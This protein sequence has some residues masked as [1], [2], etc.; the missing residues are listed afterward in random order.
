MYIEVDNDNYLKRSQPTEGEKS[1]ANL[2]NLAS[3]VGGFHVS[4]KH[5]HLQS[6]FLSVRTEES[7]LE[8]STVWHS[9]YIALKY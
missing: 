7:F 3:A 5:L 4:E 6:R 9:Q 1:P 8:K 2:E